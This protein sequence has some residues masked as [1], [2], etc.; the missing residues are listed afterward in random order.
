MTTG[1]TLIRGATLVTCDAA[2]R[3]LR[4]DLLIRDGRI[5]G[6]G[7]V[8]AGSKARV[9]D[10][11]DRI[12]LPGLVMAH[13]HLCQVLMRGMADDLPLLDWLRRRIWPLEAAHDEASIRASAELGLAE[14]LLAGTTALLDLGTVHHHDVVFDACVRS[15]IRVVGGRR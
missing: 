9:V 2:D 5:A 3:V 4:G 14:M 11:R 6:L 8:R 12:V 7:R 15:G 10:G 13:V 1:E